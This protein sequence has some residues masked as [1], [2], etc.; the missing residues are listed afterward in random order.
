MRLDPLINRLEFDRELAHLLD[1][2][3]SDVSGE[4]SRGAAADYPFR[5]FPQ[6]WGNFFIEGEDAR[7][8]SLWRVEPAR[9]QRPS[10]AA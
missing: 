1:R 2:M 7:K 4:A 5:T 10:S 3:D 9:R 8:N 6:N